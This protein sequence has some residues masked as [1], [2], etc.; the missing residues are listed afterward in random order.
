MAGFY[1]V[2]MM[3]VLIMVLAVIVWAFEIISV[4]SIV[5]SAISLGKSN[6]YAAF[7][8]RYDY[9][10]VKRFHTVSVVFF[11][12]GCIGAAVTGLGVLALFTDYTSVGSYF[13]D[14]EALLSVLIM[15]VASVGKY[16]VLLILG[17]KAFKKFAAAKALHDSI[18]ASSS[19]FCPQGIQTNQYVYGR[20]PAYY[21]GMNGFGAQRT[22][23]ENPTGGLSGNQGA[24]DGTGNSFGNT[25]NASDSV[26]T[27]SAVGSNAE[28]KEAS[29]E[30]G[31]NNIFGDTIPDKICPKCGCS[32]S[33]LYK[34]CTL[35]GEKL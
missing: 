30:N 31:N 5:F 29:A 21:Q 15:G 18:C 10:S 8:G 19:V 9:R 35:C 24:F 16:V 3:F 25:D 17:I 33:G 27:R 7:G 28:K 2:G 32:N 1:V 34:Y 14:P 11:V 26:N 22:Y 12:L 20:N 4:L 6:K 23:T 13:D